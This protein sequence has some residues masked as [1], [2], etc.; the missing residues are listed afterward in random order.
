MLLHFKRNKCI[1]QL[2][3]EF[4]ALPLVYYYTDESSTTNFCVFV[5]AIDVTSR[6]IYLSNFALENYMKNGIPVESVFF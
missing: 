1:L 2:S 4:Q 5:K 6:V 3:M